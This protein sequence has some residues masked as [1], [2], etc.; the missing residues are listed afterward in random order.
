[1]K[2]IILASSSPNRKKILTDV[3]IDFEID[4]SN[5][6]EDM[7]LPMYPHDLV[8]HLSHGKA[9]D[10]AARH[11]GGLIL[12]ADSIVV[13]GDQRLG[14]PYTS[15]RAIEMLK[16]LSGKQHQVVTGFTLI[17]LDNDKTISKAV[18]TEVFF[19]DLSDQEIEEYVATGEP[20]EKAGAYAIQQNGKKFVDKIEGSETNIAGLPVEELMKTLKEFN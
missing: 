17:D 9:A 3:G 7:T 16:M 13:Y 15:E 14:K 6:E 18:S 12:G 10:V 11:T 4:P 20:L 19:K 5:Y 2:R 1:M 8:M